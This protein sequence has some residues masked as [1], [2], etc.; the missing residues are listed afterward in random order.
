MYCTKHSILRCKLAALQMRG[1]Q[2]GRLT[3]AEGTACCGQDPGT[4][5]NCHESQCREVL[6][7][8]SK[9]RC[10]DQQSHLKTTTNL[11]M[12]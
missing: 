1:W 7:G 4:Q 5:A 9:E 3:K 6:A 11:V 12:P 8:L 2:T 10:R